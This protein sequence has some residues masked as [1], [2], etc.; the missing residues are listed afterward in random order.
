MLFTTHQH[1]DFT[2][3]VDCGGSVY[4]TKASTGARSPH[5]AGKISNANTNTDTIYHAT[6]PCAATIPPGRDASCRNETPTWL[7]EAT[8]QKTCCVLGFDDVDLYCGCDTRAN[9]RVQ[10]LQHHAT[11]TSCR[12]MHLHTYIHDCVMLQPTKACTPAQTWPR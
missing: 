2:H 6:Q 8:N 12:H 10:A 7:D 11:H 1:T 4:A 9:A 5:V 3:S